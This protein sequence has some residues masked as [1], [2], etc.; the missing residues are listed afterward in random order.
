MPDASKRRSTSAG[1]CRRTGVRAARARRQ[2]AVDAARARR[3]RPH[4]VKRHPRSGRARRGSVAHPGHAGLRR[5][6][7]GQLEHELAQNAWLTVEARDAI[8]FECPRR[9]A[10]R[11]RWS[12]AS[13]TR[14]CRTRRG[15][16]KR[17]L[18]S[19]STSVSSVLA[20]RSARLSCTPRTR[21]RPSATFIRFKNSS[22]NGARPVWWSACLRRRAASRTR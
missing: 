7:A 6:V 21:F 5:L 14:G 13:T 20:S 22:T 18:S 19:P 11:R 1:R 15:M 2:L 12:S 9:S 3:H 16:P 4:H 10:C 17:G 8:I